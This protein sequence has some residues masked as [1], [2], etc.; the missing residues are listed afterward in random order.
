MLAEVYANN[1]IKNYN[2]VATDA[3][4]EQ[5]KLREG[6]LIYAYELVVNFNSFVAEHYSTKE[7]IS[8]SDLKIDQFIDC[9]HI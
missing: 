4:L 7:S 2:S 6:D 5:I 3:S 9:K 1:I 8:D